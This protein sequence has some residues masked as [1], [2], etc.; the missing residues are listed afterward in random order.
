MTDDAD[1]LE[2]ILCGAFS[3]PPT[4]LKDIPTCTGESRKL[5]RKKAQ[6]PRR[7]RK[8]C[9]MAELIYGQNYHRRPHI[10]AASPPM[11][12]RIKSGTD[13]EQIK[14]PRGKN[15]RGFFA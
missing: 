5:K 13:K 7:Q 12:C 10:H 4:P 15:P 8:K 9:L 6:R 14:K 2:K 1:R 3:G 11:D